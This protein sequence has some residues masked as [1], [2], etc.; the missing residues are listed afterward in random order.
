MINQPNTNI[1]NNINKNNNPPQSQPK[2]QIK[3]PP[4]EK[5]EF[6]NQVDCK[7]IEI[8]GFGKTKKIKIT[9]GSPE[10]IEG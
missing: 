6:R 3:K 4:P 2:P 7:Q 10:K 5:I 9:V 1:N 8:T